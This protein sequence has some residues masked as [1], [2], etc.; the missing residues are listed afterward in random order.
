MV[1]RQLPQRRIGRRDDLDHFSERDEGDTGAAVGLRHGN[2]PQPGLRE[3]FDL[4]V[5]QTALAVALRRA[6]CQTSRQLMRHDNGLGVVLND[7]HRVLTCI[8]CMR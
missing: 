1:L 6:L 7:A 5:R 2:R 4:F 3:P 8:A